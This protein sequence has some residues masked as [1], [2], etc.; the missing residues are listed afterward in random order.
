ML[1]QYKPAQVTV[2][3]FKNART[4]WS[5]FVLSDRSALTN[6]GLLGILIFMVLSSGVLQC[7]YNCLEEDASKRASSKYEVHSNP[8][9]ASCHLPLPEP[10]QV[11]TC[12]NRSCHQSQASNRSLAGSVLTNHTN[13]LAPVLN[14]SRLPMPD[15]RICQA[16]KHKTK[17]E[18]VLLSSW[19]PPATTSQSLIGVKTTVLLN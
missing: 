4:V 2:P 12:P 6:L 18:P 3:L 13:T 10:K 16:L 17:T 11:T 7:A 19:Q 14:G 1:L 15:I 8:H 9:V 5:Y